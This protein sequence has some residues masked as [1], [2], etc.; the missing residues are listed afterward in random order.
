MPGGWSASTSPE[1]DAVDRALPARRL[2]RDQPHLRRP[3]RRVEAYVLDR[4]DLDLYGERVCVE[5]V[6]RLRPTLKY[7]GIEPLVRQMALD[8]AQ[9]REILSTIVPS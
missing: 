7:E 1:D 9:C 2:D 3:Q 4:T 8:V 5:F 6:R